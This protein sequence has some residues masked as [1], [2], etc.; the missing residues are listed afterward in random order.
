M[1]NNPIYSA[2]HPFAMHSHSVSVAM[3]DNTLHSH[4]SIGI[5]CTHRCNLHQQR[6]CHMIDAVVRRI[7]WGI[8]AV[9]ELDT[10]V[11]VVVDTENRMN[12]TVAVLVVVVV[13]A[14][15]RLTVSEQMTLTR[16]STMHWQ[17]GLLPL[18]RW[19]LHSQLNLHWYSRYKTLAG[20]GIV[21][22]S[23]AGI[24]CT[25]GTDCIAE[26]AAGTVDDDAD[27]SFDARMYRSPCC[28]QQFARLAVAECICVAAVRNTVV[29]PN[30]AVVE[31]FVFVALFSVPQITATV[32]WVNCR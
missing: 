30:T 18:L 8:S 10:D 32:C 23:V 16:H 1:P 20:L 15:G 31:Q 24:A 2:I 25:V 28:Q 11:A 27:Y 9:S 13:V 7:A 5:D 22:S 3:T 4:A 17:L 19:C 29:A 26:I 6:H 21:H 12:D 14:V